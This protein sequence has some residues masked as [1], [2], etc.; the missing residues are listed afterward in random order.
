MAKKRPRMCP[1]A[2]FRGF[3]A[4]S[5]EN[6]LAV[7]E[8]LAR[9]PKPKHES[10][11]AEL[12]LRPARVRQLARL[13]RLPPTVQTLLEAG[14][15]TPKHGEYLLTL[16]PAKRAAMAERAA[17]GRWK[18]ARLRTEIGAASGARNDDLPHPDPNLDSL[19]VELTELVG[20][21]VR[22][23]HRAD[24]SGWLRIRYTSLDTMDGLLERLGYRA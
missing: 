20:G 3:M 5:R 15:L 16:P 19:E 6:W 23:D 2:L 12:D 8:A 11:A 22:I 10:I 14:S 13:S 9:S 7:R 18:I 21:D 24:G 1:G 17:S 4:T